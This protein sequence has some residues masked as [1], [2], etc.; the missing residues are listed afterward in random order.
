MP[1]LNWIGK[2]AVRAHHREVDFHLLRDVPEMACGGHGAGS[3]EPGESGNLIV[4]G[5][6]LRA[7]KALLTG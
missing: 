5:D 2:S 7:L 6:N 4:Q 1:E 3:A